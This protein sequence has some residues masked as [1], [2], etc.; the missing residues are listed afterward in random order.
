M[1]R[2]VDGSIAA[3][4]PSD[5]TVYRTPFTTNGVSSNPP[6][7]DSGL[8]LTMALSGDGQRQATSSCVTL[9][10]LIWLSAEYRLL[11]ASPP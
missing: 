2:P 3:N 7:R 5:V 1:V 10:R 6:G 9:V 4:T 11:P 8:A